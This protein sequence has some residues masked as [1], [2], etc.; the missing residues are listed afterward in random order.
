MEENDDDEELVNAFETD[1][2]KEMATPGN[3]LAGYRLKHNL[4]QRQLAEM[5]GISYSTI[6]AYETGKRPLSQR[7]AVKL[8]NA[9]GEQPERFFQEQ[10]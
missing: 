6:S 7:T 2:W 4:T 5:T 9:M 10:K 1:W 8:A 3:L